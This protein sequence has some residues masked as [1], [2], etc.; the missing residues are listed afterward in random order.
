MNEMKRQKIL[1]IGNVSVDIKAYSLEEDTSEAYRD[2][3]IDLVPG[4]V[5]R[6]MAMNLNHLG[7]DSYIY[8][9][10]GDDIFGDYLRHGMNAEG[11]NTKLLKTIPGQSTSLFR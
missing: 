8:S 11:I 5:G 1:S 7:L 10:V 4:G 3:T 2:G 9:A 6:G